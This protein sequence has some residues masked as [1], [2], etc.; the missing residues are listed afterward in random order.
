MSVL[1]DC[2]PRNPR[3]PSYLRVAIPTDSTDRADHADDKRAAT[4]DL[5]R[6]LQS[7]LELAHGVQA[8]VSGRGDAT[9][10][11]VQVSGYADFRVGLPQV[12]VV[13]QVKHFE[14]ELEGSRFREPEV[15]EQ[16]RIRSPVHGP[17]QG[18]SANVAE[19]SHRRACVWTSRRPYWSRVEPVLLIS[20]GPDLADKV[21]SA[22]SGIPILAAIAI[23][24][25]KG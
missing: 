1:T 19:G 8:A 12:D 22:W 5:E 23:R 17:G 2:H 14:A 13:E 18:V 24:R 6:Q 11:V 4:I 10:V 9:R 7:K 25:S 20:D 21:G 15:F 16:R 3:N